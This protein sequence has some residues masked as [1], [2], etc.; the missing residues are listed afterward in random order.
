MSNVIII[1]S[2]AGG[3]AAAWRLTSE[4]IKVQILEAGP[5]FDPQADYNQDKSNWETPFPVKDGSQGK[6]I[7]APLQ[8][9]T[10][11]TSDIRSWSLMNGKYVQGD[12]RT[13][14]GYH[15]VRGFG[16]S[17]LH[18]TG[19]A[20]RLNPK[21]MSLQ[22]EYGIG[23]DWPFQYEE[24]EPYWR[25]AEKI[26]GVCGPRLE[27]RQPASDRT[28]GTPHPLSFASQMLA[29]GARKIGLT[30]IEN[31]LAVNSRPDDDRADCNYCGGCLRGCQRGDKGSVD[32]TYLRRAMHTG[33]LTVTSGAEVL[34][35]LTNANRI[36]G[37][38]AAVNGKLQKIEADLVV[39]SAGSVFSPQILLN[40]SSSYAPDGL[41]NESGQVGKNLMETLLTTS[42]ALHP[43]KLGSH[44][45]L[46]VDWISWDYNDPNSIPNVV[47]G[48]RFSPSTAESDLVGP[49]AY[50]TRV[51]D[52]WGVKHKYD[53]KKT[54]GRILSIAGIGESLPN[55]KS[56]VDLAAETNTFG[57]PLPR[58]HS[59][60]DKMAEDRLRFMMTI[61]RKILASSGCSSPLEEF[62]SID[63]FS[64]THIFGTCRMG[65]LEN[66]C[67]V[68]SHGQSF[69][70]PN[71]FI[72]DASIFP[73]S[74]GGESPGLTIQAL[75]IRSADRI[76][77]RAGIK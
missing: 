39:L 33:N 3:A 56:F 25:I 62:S 38:L 8:P 20:H 59:Y 51:V 64:S 14:F 45:G 71:L 47:G 50:A 7:V 69:R 10:E 41:C 60:V 74:G 43:D 44:R 23:A 19:E 6:Y 63:A 73:S 36:T 9:L 15:H 31:S 42:T 49:I 12:V 27:Y 58:I 46:P 30:V 40:S 76:L 2:G 77:K 34:Q 4:G 29:A 21:S 37:V 16:G 65:N 55:A 72:A 18:F 1:G 67:V 70:W 32:V 5:T 57:L 35:I 66:E 17:S 28:L 54:F 13:S 11:E 53:M 48:C 52:G 75:A 26:S 61:C 22:S 68:N 24:L